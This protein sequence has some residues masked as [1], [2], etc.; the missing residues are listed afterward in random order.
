[1]VSDRQ[2]DCAR[3]GLTRMHRA[4]EWHGHHFLL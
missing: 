2:L 3:G 1:L 4:A